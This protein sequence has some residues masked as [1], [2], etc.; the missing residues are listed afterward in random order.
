LRN[1]AALRAAGQ[2]NKLS[3]LGDWRASSEI[4]K[5]K[6]DEAKLELYARFMQRVSRFICRSR[7]QSCTVEKDFIIWHYFG[8]DL[9]DFF[10]L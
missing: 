9:I 7:L 1:D 8:F 10:R 6:N 3:T 4:R 5:Q 2:R